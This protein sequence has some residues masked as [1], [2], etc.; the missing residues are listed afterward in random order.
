MPSDTAVLDYTSQEVQK[1]AFN[2][3]MIKR[4]KDGKPEHMPYY[5]GYLTDELKEMA[6]RELHETEERKEASLKK[7][8]QLIAGMLMISHYSFYKF[9][10]DIC[11]VSIQIKHFLALGISRE[12]RSIDD[13][14]FM[15]QTFGY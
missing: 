7:F 1:N 15:K 4:L 5:I 12:N 8:R 3:K 11:E 14:F 2:N 10:K 6:E 13:H 9:F